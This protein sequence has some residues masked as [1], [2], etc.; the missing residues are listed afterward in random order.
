MLKW[1][2]VAGKQYLKL[3]SLIEGPELEP[4]IFHS[5]YLS[6][7]AIA[8]ARRRIRLLLRG[9][10]LDVGAGSGHGRQLL[11]A[12]TNYFPTDVEGAR[13]YRD[14]TLTRKGVPLAKRCSVY[15]IDYPDNRF[16]GCMAL[17]LFEHLQYPD[18]AIVEVRRVVKKDGYIVLLVP[19]NFPVHGYPEDYWRWTVEG[20]RHLLQSHGVQVTECFSCG[21]TVHSFS[22]N[23]NLFLREGMVLNGHVPSTPRAIVYVLVRPVLTLLFLTVNVLASIFGLLD[24]SA[25]SPILVCAIGRN[26]KD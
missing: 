25:T 19:F 8:V 18:K 5:H 12:D 4:T 7:R 11:A 1:I 22:L 9:D 3:F 24:K 21:N 2:E 23:L 16:D 10:I 17:S 15:D 13:D 14:P 20:L 26:S 6:T